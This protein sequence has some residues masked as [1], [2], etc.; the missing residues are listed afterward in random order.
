M[1][2]EIVIAD[3]NGP[4]KH[5]YENML[6]WQYEDKKEVKSSVSR[7]LFE[8]FVIDWAH[9]FSFVLKRSSNALISSS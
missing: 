1:Q 3:F 9:N 4:G 7:V 2:R 6:G 5:L 8:T